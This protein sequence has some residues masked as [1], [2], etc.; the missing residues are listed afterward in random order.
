MTLHGHLEVTRL[1]PDSNESGWWLVLAE[2]LL[3]PVFRWVEDNDEDG[4]DDGVA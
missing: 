1:E 3:R 2:P 4:D